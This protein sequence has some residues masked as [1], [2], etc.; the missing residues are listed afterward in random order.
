VIPAAQNPHKGPV[1]GPTDA[2][3]VKMLEIGLK[4]L[5]F[6]DIDL[7]EINRGGVSYAI[8]TVREYATRV[9]KENLYL[10]I[11][12]DQFEKLDTWKDYEELLSLTNVIVVSRP[13]HQMPF[14]PEDLPP[15]IQKLVGAFDRSYIQLTTGMGIEFLRLQDVDVSSTAVRKYLRSGRATDRQLTIPVEQFLKDQKI[16]GPL[17]DRIGD[18]EK[19]AKFCASVLNERKAINIRGFDLRNVEGPAEFTLVASG[20]STRHAGSLAE[21]VMRAVKEEYN[22]HPQSIEGLTEGRWVLLDYGALIIHLFYD[23]VRQEYRLEELWKN[24]RPLEIPQDL[25]ATP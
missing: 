14:S 9:K 7:Q 17:K 6:V 24:G 8:D 25:K 19:F 12:L 10:I 2:Q 11:G 22:V 3:R 13:G 4:D 15:G 18:F 1:E 5:D 16:Y 20:T 21:N 23:Y